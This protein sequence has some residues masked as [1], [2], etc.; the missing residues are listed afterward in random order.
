MDSVGNIE[1]YFVAET[2]WSWHP[3]DS[4]TSRLRPDI[5]ASASRRRFRRDVKTMTFRK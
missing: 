4:H 5:P 2:F 3:R 1:F